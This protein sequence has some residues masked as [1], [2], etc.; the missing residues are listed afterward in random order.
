MVKLQRTLVLTTVTIAG[1]FLACITQS[2][3]S[4]RCARPLP[5]SAAQ[6]S[7]KQSGDCNSAKKV[8]SWW[9]LLCVFFLVFLKWTPKLNF[10]AWFFLKNFLAKVLKWYIC[11]FPETFIVNTEQLEI[12]K[13][14][15]IYFKNVVRIPYDRSMDFNPL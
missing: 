8:R 6:R 1:R 4:K 5:W 14:Y 11:L 7:L 10:L 9:Q 12:H 13:C 15:I 2:I 3:H